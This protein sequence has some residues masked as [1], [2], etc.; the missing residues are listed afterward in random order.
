MFNHQLTR[1]LLPIVHCDVDSLQTHFLPLYEEVGEVGF[2]HVVTKYPSVPE[3]YFILAKYPSVP[4]NYY[5]LAKYPSVPENYYI[6]A[7]HR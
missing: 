5:V 4:E 7:K 6:S 3:N 1:V 2:A